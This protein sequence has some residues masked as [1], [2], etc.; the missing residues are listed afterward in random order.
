MR[1]PG[2]EA[3]VEDRR[4]LMSECLIIERNLRVSTRVSK[5]KWDPKQHADLEHEQ[6]TGRREHA[7]G[8]ISIN[9]I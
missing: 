2:R 8:I 6:S 5:L 7:N 1:L 4:A 3:S 9:T